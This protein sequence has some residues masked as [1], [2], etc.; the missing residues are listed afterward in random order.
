MRLA[1]I[2]LSVGIFLAEHVMANGLEHMFKKLGSDSNYTDSGSFQD[3]AVGHYTLGGLATRQK[4]QSV[5]PINIR[6][7]SGIGQGSCGNMDMRFGGFSFMEAKEF[8]EMLK[9]TGKGLPTYGFQLAMKTYVPQIEG[10][11]SNLR[12]Y[13]Q[14]INN[15]TLDDCRM[16]QAMFDAVLPAQGTMREHLCQDIRRNGGEADFFG[17]MS[18]C[19]SEEAQHAHKK[20]NKYDDLLSGEY[21]LVWKALQHI[22]KYKG[23][24]E[25]SEFMMTVVGTVISRKS[26][27]SQKSVKSKM[28][29]VPS[30]YSYEL[31]TISPKGDERDFVAAFLDGGKSSKLVCNDQE[32]CLNPKLKETNIPPSESMTSR[33]IRVVNNLQIKY[34]SGAALNDEEKSILGDAYSVPLLKYIQVSAAA[35]SNVMLL[36]DAAHFIANSLILVQFDAISAEIMEAV[37][38]LESIQIDTKAVK[39]FK[40]NLQ[41]ARTRIQAQMKKSDFD[42][43]WRLNQHI[44]SL[45]NIIEA[46]NE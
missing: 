31:H 30:E 44:K 3:Q 7:P 9:R 43:I 37:E 6:L 15:M 29:D 45:E 28:N 18:K 16:R 41:H 25:V 23:N 36:K 38:V 42:G 11:M 24:K 22:P 4:N 14:K 27:N 19:R 39:Q 20:D 26:P 33:V 8:M 2:L 40:E 21:N 10:L 17:A 1:G 5:Q 46:S 32:D 34:R 35:N 12:D 13:L